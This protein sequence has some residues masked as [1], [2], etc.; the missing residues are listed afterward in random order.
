M[1]KK[2]KPPKNTAQ[3]KEKKKVLIP[4]PVIPGDEKTL[5]DEMADLFE[6]DQVTHRHGRTEPERD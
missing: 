5:H 3:T 2:S 6:E 1:G 4:L